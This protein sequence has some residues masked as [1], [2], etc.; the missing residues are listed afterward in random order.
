MTRA[1]LT[2][3]AAV[4]SATL[5]CAHHKANQYSYAPP[6]APAVYPQP[7]QSAPVAFP[8]PAT[9]PP[10]NV[11]A[12]GAAAP[13]MVPPTA[14]AG[15]VP[16]TADGACPTGCDGTHGAVPVAYETAVQTP[17]CPQGP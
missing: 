2:L 14:S 8:A 13:P 12:P 4:C 16:A 5:G 9:L 10:G 17:P 11:I 7:Q 15:V 3:F 1:I 6:L